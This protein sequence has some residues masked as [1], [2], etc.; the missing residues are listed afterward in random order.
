MGNPSTKVRDNEFD[1]VGEYLQIINFWSSCAE[2]VIDS[3][4]GKCDFPMD[5][6]DAD[7]LICQQASGMKEVF[8]NER[9]LAAF[10]KCLRCDVE[11]G[12][13]SYSLTVRLGMVQLKSEPTEGSVVKD[14]MHQ[15][16]TV[17]ENATSQPTAEF[18]EQSTESVENRGSESPAKPILVL[19]KLCIE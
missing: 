5:A 19:R 12:A 2:F 14:E 16:S 10:K 15:I 4:D 17:S 11:N 8:E 6:T 7:H 1:N 18:S 13:T 3:S 9:E